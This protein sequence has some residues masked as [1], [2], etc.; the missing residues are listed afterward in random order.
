MVYGDGGASAPRVLVV[1]AHAMSIY[2]H[3]TTALT[4]VLTVLPQ[5]ERV[6]VGNTVI[7]V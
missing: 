7:T 5:S 2:H 3:T 1:A 6:R 4:Q